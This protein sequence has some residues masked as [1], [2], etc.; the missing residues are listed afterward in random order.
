MA[1][2]TWDMNTDGMAHYGLMPDWI[3]DLRK[4]G[5]QEI[6]DDLLGGAEAYLRTWGAAEAH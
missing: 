1:Q 5:G 4:V 2:R 6:V 3:E